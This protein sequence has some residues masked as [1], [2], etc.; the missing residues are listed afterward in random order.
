MVRNNVTVE[1]AVDVQR[2]ESGTN[3]AL[4]ANNPAGLVSCTHSS[5]LRCAGA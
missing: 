2:T 1:M 5:T 4:V 3:P